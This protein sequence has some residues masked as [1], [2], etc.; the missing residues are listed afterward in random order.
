MYSVRQEFILTG[1]QRD[2]QHSSQNEL[3]GL[4]KK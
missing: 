2:A 1:P 4:S 3:F